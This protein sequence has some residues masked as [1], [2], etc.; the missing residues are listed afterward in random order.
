MKHY[1]K[2]KY[3]WTFR[4]ED[5]FIETI[6]KANGNGD[7]NLAQYSLESEES[8]SRIFHA[9]AGFSQHGERVLFISLLKYLDQYGI[10]SALFADNG[11]S[12]LSSLK[13]LNSTRGPFGGGSAFGPE[14]DFI[15]F[16]KDITLNPDK[17]H[18]FS[19]GFRKGYLGV[20]AQNNLLINQA[21][22]SGKPTPSLIFPPKEVDDLAYGVV[23][24]AANGIVRT[25]KKELEDR[26]RYYFSDEF[27]KKY[28]KYSNRKNSHESNQN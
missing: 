1:S 12:F 9:G 3:S 25:T 28:G 26:L 14:H 8:K 24:L 18:Q 10:D 15:Y 5:R 23:Q 16:E 11:K 7:M 4:L 17:T 20:D 19:D 27:L 22:F 13:K 2:G 6:I 21:N